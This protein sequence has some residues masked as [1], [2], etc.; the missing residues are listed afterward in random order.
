MTNLT[1]GMAMNTLTCEKTSRRAK[2]YFLSLKI[3]SEAYYYATYGLHLKCL[4]KGLRRR[5]PCDYHVGLPLVYG[6]EWSNPTFS[7]THL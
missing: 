1:F 2:T 4:L 6:H 5:R 7:Y 3:K